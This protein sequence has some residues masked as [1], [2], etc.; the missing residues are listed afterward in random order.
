MRRALCAHE[1]VDPMLPRK[2]PEELIAVLSVPQTNSGGRDEY[3]KALER[4][5]PK[6]LGKILP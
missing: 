3:S 4:T 1:L 5:H 6:E 2:A